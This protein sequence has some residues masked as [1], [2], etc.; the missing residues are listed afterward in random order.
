MKYVEDP[1]SQIGTRIAKDDGQFSFKS[2]LGIVSKG[3]NF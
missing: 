1:G 3:G 2:T